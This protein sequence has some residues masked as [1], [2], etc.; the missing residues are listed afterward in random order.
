MLA[1]PSRDFYSKSLLVLHDGPT[2]GSEKEGSG[3]AAGAL[4]SGPSKGLIF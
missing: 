4:S 2:E 3:A 1:F